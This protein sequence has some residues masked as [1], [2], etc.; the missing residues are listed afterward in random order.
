MRIYNASVPDTMP[1]LQ[2]NRDFRAV[3]KTSSTRTAWTWT[4]DRIGARSGRRSATASPFFYFERDDAY[5]INPRP[6]CCGVS[7]W[8]TS[9]VFFGKY[10]FCELK[11]ARG[12]SKPSKV[13]PRKPQ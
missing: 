11:A 7:D 1:F 2:A 4:T 12:F 6:S 13:V 9:V 10:V 3:R 5:R 8:R